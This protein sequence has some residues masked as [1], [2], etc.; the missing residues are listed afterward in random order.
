M[1]TRTQRLLGALDA[2]WEVLPE[3]Y[4]EKLTGCPVCPLGGSETVY[5]DDFCAECGRQMNRA[6]HYIGPPLDDERSVWV[7]WR[8]AKTFGEQVSV[9]M[10]ESS[11]DCLI[12][13]DNMG[14]G[15]I[16]HLALLAA[17][18]ARAGLAKWEGA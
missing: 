12:D 13:G 3:L 10:F 2:P 11:A 14:E 16:P 8:I 17:I 9:T 4:H 7:L 1:N 18:E 5:G 6:W 15:S